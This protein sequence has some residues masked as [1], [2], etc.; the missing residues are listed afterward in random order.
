MSKMADFAEEGPVASVERNSL[1]AKCSI[2]FS[3]PRWLHTSLHAIDF[4][5]F[6]LGLITLGNDRRNGAASLY[7]QSGLDNLAD[8]SFF[9][10]LHYDR[11]VPSYICVL[12]RVDLDLL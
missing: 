11:G 12:W 5:I 4:D 10:V 7:G 8:K 3:P 6:A 1:S 2:R 9:D